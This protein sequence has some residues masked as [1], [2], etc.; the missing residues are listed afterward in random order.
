MSY[1]KEAIELQTED[2]SIIAEEIDASKADGFS[3]FA[4]VL[5]P[6]EAM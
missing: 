2:S 3:V 4:F 1:S 6:R 5:N